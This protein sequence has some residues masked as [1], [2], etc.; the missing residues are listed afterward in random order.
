MALEFVAV[1]L[2]Q[3]VISQVVEKLGDLLANEAKSLRSVRDD[4]EYLKSEL[5]FMNGFLK[6][7]D[8]RQKQEGLVRDWIAEVRDV[9]CEIEDAIE[10]YVSEVDSAF[11]KVIRRR[12]LQAL[13]A[14]ISSIKNK[15]QSLRERRLTYQIQLNAEEG[16]SSMRNLRKSYPEE[17]EDVVSMKDV[18]MTLKAQL[19]KEEDQLRVVSIV[20][21]GGLGKTT[22]AKKVYSDIGVKRHFDMYAWVC[23]SQQYVVKEVLIEILLQ[24]GFERKNLG[25]G[26]SKKEFL[27]EKSNERELLKRFEEQELIGLIEDE[28]KEKKYLV[29]L[30]DIWNIEAWHRIKKVFPEGRGGS[31]LLFTTRNTE[32]AA[33]VGPFVPPIEPPL[34]TEEESW[35][36]LQRKAFSGQVFGN[37]GS[38]SEF[39]KLGKEMVRKCG[40]LPLAVVVLGGLLSTKTALGEWKKVHKDVSFQLNKLKSPQQ[41][42]V[43]EILDLSYQELPFFLKPCFLYL[44]CFPEDSEISKKRLIR[45]WIAEGFVPRPTRGGIEGTLMEEV[46]EHYLGELINRSMVQV[47]RRDLTGDGVKTCRFHDL[48]RDFCISK[49]R[50]ENFFEIMAPHK[51]SIVAAGSSSVQYSSTTHSRRIAFHFDDGLGSHAPWMEK[52]NTNL[53]SLICFGINIFPTLSLKNGNLKLLRVLELVF[54]RFR[55]VKVPKEIGNLIHLR[56]LKFR[57]AHISKL[58]NSVGNLRYLHTLDLRDGYNF[59]RISGN[60]ISKLVHLRH[61]LL[62]D[63]YYSIF[64]ENRSSLRFEK[65]SNLETLKTVHAENLI[66]CDAVVKLTNLRDLGVRFKS[67]EEVSLILHSLGSKLAHLRSLRLI[68]SVEFPSL[69]ILFDCAALYKLHLGGRL[70]QQHSSFLPKSLV[71]LELQHSLLNQDIVVVLEKMENLRILQYAYD[72]YNYHWGLSRGAIMS[73]MVFSAHGFPKLEILRLVGL[74][75]LEEW[76]VGE[77]AMANLMR[78]DISYIPKLKMIPDGMKYVTNLQEL[79]ISQ[80]SRKF[81]GRLRVIDGVEGEDFHKVQ[82]IPSICFSLTDDD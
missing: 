54:D 77:D 33:S 71:K 45:L 34:L 30:D 63:W 55:R 16:T 3:A 43:E 9:A 42:A 41:Y 74:G 25:G 20:G 75:D 72:G 82:H 68:L 70:S 50:N 53:R 18:V 22:L 80:M 12:K 17:E 59:I 15:L 21:M 52:V 10:I 27:T 48:M 4:V 78:L 81:E 58:P 61:L 11:I 79:N 67:A 28:L 19:L 66:R 26:K 24:V 51:T 65:L 76:E 14:R 40:G 60:S 69:D 29:V 73:K 39:E 36:L 23:I 13:R 44:S 37:N 62:P 56:Y 6:D 57:G 47:A 31:K 5:K 35:E 32:L 49:A 1:Q 2:G 64:W 7:A 38:R 8:R 46:A